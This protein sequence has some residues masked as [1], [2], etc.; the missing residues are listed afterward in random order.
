MV[1][2]RVTRKS[3]SSLPPF[4]A[5]TCAGLTRKGKDG[6]YVSTESKNGVFQWKKIKSI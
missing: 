2:Q 1:C 6:M 3:G 5:N 4:I